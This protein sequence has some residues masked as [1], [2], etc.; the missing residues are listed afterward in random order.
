VRL[1]IAD[2]VG[3]VVT[4]KSMATLRNRVGRVEPEWQRT[5][6]GDQAQERPDTAS[7]DENELA[8]LQ[9]VRS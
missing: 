1:L 9:P 8:L 5:P 2:I 3:E 6:A 4:R 7:D